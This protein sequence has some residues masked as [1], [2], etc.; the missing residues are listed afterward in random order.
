MARKKGHSDLITG[1]FA[2]GAILS[3]VGMVVYLQGI[4]L[5]S[6]GARYTVMFD[7]VG[8]LGSN[9]RVV[10][11]GRNVGEVV[12]IKTVPVGSTATG[13]R[14][15]VE[16][17]FIIH[18]D[19][20]DAVTI[21]LDT[22]AEVQM[23]SIFGFGG[24]RLV[25]KLGEVRERVQPGQILPRLG[26]PPLN[27][28]DLANDVEITVRRLQS[29]VDKLAAVI[30]DDEFSG[31]ID[32][33]L[34][35]LR[36]ALETMDRGLKELEPAFSKVGPTFDAANA[37][38]TDLRGVLDANKEAIS[39]MLANFESASGKLD[40]LMD[41]DGDGVPRL[42]ASLNLIAGN[43]DSLVKNLNDVIVDNNLNIQVSLANVRETTESLRVFARRIENDPSLLIWGGDGD[44]PD[45]KTAPVRVTPAVDEF[46]IR[47]SGRRPRKESD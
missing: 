21:P 38:V 11:A 7:D 35:R 34:R 23:G 39:T 46:A 19:Y 31:N 4:E 26:K 1:A 41:D 14:V 17:Q 33:S 24:T 30:S 20:S 6:E 25:L 12:G 37:L 36:S 44:V 43:L 13:S 40:R 16:V 47:D 29:G 3:F 27:M 42:V 22:V 32:E 45:P 9:S 15:Q 18:E 8:G 10:V 28:N 2:L 5:G